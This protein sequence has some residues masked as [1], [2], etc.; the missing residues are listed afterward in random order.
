MSDNYRVEIPNAIIKVEVVNMGGRL[1]FVNSNNTI[2]AVVK[3]L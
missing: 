1:L 3:L 2:T